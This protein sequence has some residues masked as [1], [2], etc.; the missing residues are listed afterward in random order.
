MRATVRRSSSASALLLSVVVTSAAMAQSSSITARPRVLRTPASVVAAGMGDAG[1]VLVDPA[2]VF[3]NPAMLPQA[4]GVSLSGHRLDARTINASIASVQSVGG[5][6]VGL[7]AR[8]LGFREV[9]PRISVGFPQPDS[10]PGTSVAL[11]AAVA[12]PLGPLRLGVSATYAR[13]SFGRSGLEPGRD[14]VSMAD[15]TVADIGVTMPFGPGNALN[16]AATVQHLG[17]GYQR[18]VGDG[19]HPWRG[20]LAFGG[21]NY[22]FA[23]FWDV[24]AVTQLMVDADGSV[25]HAAGAELAWVPVE[26]V[27]VAAR[28]GLRSVDASDRFSAGRYTGGLGVSVDRWS[29]DWALE[30]SRDGR[31]AAHRFGVRIR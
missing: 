26:G 2:V 31:P 30:A 8:L 4:S 28:T 22:P 12:R 6:T 19:E 5:L 20:I 15:V 29:L 18:G 16:V 7:G 10:A 11:T 13:E 1:V 3:Y 9:V 27:S 23:T 17:P 21:R 24:S 14:V 25:H